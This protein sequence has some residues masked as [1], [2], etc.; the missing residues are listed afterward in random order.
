MFLSPSLPPPPP[1]PPLPLLIFLL[2]LFRLRVYTSLFCIIT[3]HTS[4]FSSPSIF[5]LSI[6]RFFPY[7]SWLSTSAS[8]LL[9]FFRS[10]AFSS[11]FYRHIFSP[12]IILCSCFIFSSF[13]I[14]SLS[15]ISSIF[16]VFLSCLPPR[17]CLT[18]HSLL[19]IILRF[20]PSFTYLFYAHISPLSLVLLSLYPSPALPRSLSFSF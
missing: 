8:L 19:P 2:S 9:S 15:C 4:S 13:F 18:H 1:P 20:V 5:F 11:S 17:P 6:L 14:L 12:F 16:L 3:S 10:L 7:S